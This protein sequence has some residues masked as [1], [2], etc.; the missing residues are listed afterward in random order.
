M[1][2]LVALLPESPY[3]QEEPAIWGKNCM[4]H[5]CLYTAVK[6]KKKKKKKKKDVAGEYTLRK[7]VFL[8]LH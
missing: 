7:E 8:N 1:K 3:F 5:E 6:K 2:Q 4:V